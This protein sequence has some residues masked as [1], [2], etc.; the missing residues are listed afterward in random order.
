MLTLSDLLNF[1]VILH[2]KWGNSIA[3]EARNWS[4]RM[5]LVDGCSGS[6]RNDHMHENA[7]G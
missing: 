5:L 3:I 7:A 4:L 6:Q 1:L 2:L